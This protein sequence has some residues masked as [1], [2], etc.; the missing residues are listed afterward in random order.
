LRKKKCSIETGGS[1]FTW[2]GAE[3]RRV[4]DVATRLAEN[5]YSNNDAGEG[6]HE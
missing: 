1:R 3:S 5:A 6:R 2:P 4:I